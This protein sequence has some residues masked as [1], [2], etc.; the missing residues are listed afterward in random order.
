MYIII[1]FLGEMTKFLLFAFTLSLYL[2]KIEAFTFE[3]HKEYIYR[4]ITRYYVLNL[5]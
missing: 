2:I 4:D 5:A 3:I 1:Y